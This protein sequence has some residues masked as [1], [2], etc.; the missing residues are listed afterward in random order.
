[1]SSKVEFDEQVSTTGH[2]I[3]VVT[4]RAEK[5]LN[6][7]D[8]DMI[9]AL[10]RQLHNWQADKGVVCVFLQGSG[11]KAFCAGGDVRAIRTGILEGR[12]E[13]A[14]QFFEQEYRLDYLIH[15]MP[16]GDLLG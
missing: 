14:Q 2:R 15:T 5:S 6:A 11:D 3:G 8:Q 4:L 16:T 10:Y 1:M 12:P 7:L 13:I 9:T